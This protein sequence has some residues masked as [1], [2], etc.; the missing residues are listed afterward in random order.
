MKLYEYDASGWL[1]GDHDDI[2]RP[3]STGIAPTCQPN[4][5]RWDGEQWREDL[6]REAS[7]AIASRT[8][9]IYAAYEDAERANRTPAGAVQLAEWCAAGNPRALAVRAWLVAIYAERDAKLDQAEQGDLT[10]DPTPSAPWKPWTFR[11]IAQ[12][13]S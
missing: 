2:S 7:A 1:V 11:Q 10:V 3:R 6:S 8:G 9:P 5:A 4:R 13:T 12:A